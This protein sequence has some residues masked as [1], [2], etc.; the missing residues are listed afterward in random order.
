MPNE[1]NYSEALQV[2][3][4]LNEEN[5][6]SMMISASKLCKVHPLFLKLSEEIG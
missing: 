5:S 1:K 2:A 3:E 6:P 4:F